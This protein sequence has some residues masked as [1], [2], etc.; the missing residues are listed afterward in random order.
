M[1]VGSGVSM[2][3]LQALASDPNEILHVSSPSDLND[4]VQD[5]A[6]LICDNSLTDSKQF[7]FNL[8]LEKHI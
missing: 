8:L 4:A 6:K 2:T 3:Q 5:I 7:S 1:G